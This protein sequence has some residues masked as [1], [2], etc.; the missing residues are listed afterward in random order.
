MTPHT[1]VSAVQ[2]KVMSFPS[3]LARNGT[4]LRFFGPQTDTNRGGLARLAAWHLQGGP[5]GP[6]G[7]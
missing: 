6:P 5:V 3:P 2:L 4:D 1:R 7:R